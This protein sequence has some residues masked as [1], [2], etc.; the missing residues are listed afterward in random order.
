MGRK[1]QSKKDRRVRKHGGHDE[2]SDSSVDSRGNIR[3]IIDYDSE[4]EDDDYV[5]RRRPVRKAAIL[6]KKRIDKELSH[7]KKRADKELKKKNP[8]AKLGDV[9]FFVTQQIDR[10]A[11]KHRAFIG[12]CFAGDDIH[13]GRFTGTIGA[14]DAAQFTRR[15]VQA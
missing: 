4:E 5:P 15:N 1:D 2:D 14:D 3:G 12:P 8:N 6:A 11:E 13:H 9:G 7:S 10:A